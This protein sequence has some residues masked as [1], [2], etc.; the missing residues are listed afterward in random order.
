MILSDESVEKVTEK[1]RGRPRK[2][3]NQPAKPKYVAP[4]RER[5]RPKKDARGRGRPRKRPLES[6]G[7]AGTSP[8]KLK[9]LAAEEAEWTVAY[10]N[11][12]S[13]GG[14]GSE[15]RVEGSSY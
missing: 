9:E 10:Y 12:D 1:R 13:A 7:E 8:K 15:V 2:F 5:G 14:S 11:P 6:D 3:P 4:K